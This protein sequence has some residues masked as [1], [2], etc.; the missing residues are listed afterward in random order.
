MLNTGLVVLKAAP[1]VNLWCYGITRRTLAAASIEA[2]FSLLF[3]SLAA[4]HLI[5]GHSEDFC[6][7]KF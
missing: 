6:G 4:I 1:A 3:V 5:S 2:S 7:R